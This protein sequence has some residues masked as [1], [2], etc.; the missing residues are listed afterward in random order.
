MKI[1]NI[2]KENLRNFNNVFKNDLTY[3]DNIK[4]HKKPGLHPHS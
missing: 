2:D 1:V 4:I 3:D